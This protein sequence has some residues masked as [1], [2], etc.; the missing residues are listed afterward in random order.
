MSF[1]THHASLSFWLKTWWDFVSSALKDYWKVTSVLQRLWSTSPASCPSSF[2]NWQ[3]CDAGRLAACM[4][5]VSSQAG[6]LC[7]KP[8][9]AF[10]ISSSLP[11]SLHS[12]RTQKVRH[13]KKWAVH[14]N[15]LKFPCHA[16]T[17]PSKYL[18]ASLSPDRGSLPGA[19]QSLGLR[20]NNGWRLSVTSRSPNA[21]S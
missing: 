1:F 3:T 20:K 7:P 15:P 19:V 10:P 12:T 18:L 8:Q 4:R 21:R 17:W 16:L 14:P 13:Q 5:E 2:I 9:S 6:L 11:K